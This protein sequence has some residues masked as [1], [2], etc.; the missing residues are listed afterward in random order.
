[1]SAIKTMTPKEQVERLRAA[2]F[3]T[4][5]RVLTAFPEDRLDMRPAAKSRTA[6]ELV[7][8][9]I[10][11]EY[12]CRTA[13]RGE[14]P[15]SGI[16]ETWPAGLEELLRLFDRIHSETQDVLARAGDAELDVVFDFNGHQVTALEVLWIEL[17][18]QIH[19]RGQFSVYLRIVDAKLPSIYGPT[20]DDPPRS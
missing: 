12:V 16:P 15:Y 3:A 2:E 7:T 4:T 14:H 8:T 11:E 6:R 1:M 10:T 17:L 19:H 5:M 13:L 9:F 18:D 20:A